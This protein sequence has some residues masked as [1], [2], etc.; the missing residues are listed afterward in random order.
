MTTPVFDPPR[1]PDAGSVSV[2]TEARTRRADFGDGYS[3]RS[4]DGLNSIKRS[5]SLNWTLLETSEADTIIAFF[6][7]RGGHEAFL[8]TPPQETTQRKWVAASWTRES[9]TAPNRASLSVTFEEVFDL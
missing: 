8:W 7:A 9:A 1:C 4:A 2:V 5:V 3:Q 6:E